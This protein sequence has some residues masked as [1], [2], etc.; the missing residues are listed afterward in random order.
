[1]RKP[2]KFYHKM[3]SATGSSQYHRDFA[4]AVKTQQQRE[5]EG[6]VKVPHVAIFPQRTVTA[7]SIYKVR[8]RLSRIAL[9]KIRRF[10]PS[11]LKRIKTQI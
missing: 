6:T 5:G 8:V 3:P 10:N 7:E 9:N 4:K 11:I 2:N 1:M